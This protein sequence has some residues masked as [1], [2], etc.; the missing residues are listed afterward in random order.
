MR[1]A[2]AALLLLLTG[3]TAM[4]GEALSTTAL[5]PIEGL[6]RIPGSDCVIEIL[7]DSL[8]ASGE[9]ARYRLTVVSADDLA[10]EEGTVIGEA[11]PTA[12]Y[13]VY[14]SRIYTDVEPGRSLTPTS[15]RRV[16]LTLDEEESRLTAKRYGRNITLRWWRLLPY[17]LRWAL[18]VTDDKAPDTDGLVKI[19]PETAL[20]ENPV[21][22]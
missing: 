16:T 21:Y 3:L 22:L 1:Q 20:P 12:A 17:M 5:H 2:V 9:V 6:W 19:Y 4:A 13:G 10:V 15:P 8:T 11:I 14:D 7:R 18:S